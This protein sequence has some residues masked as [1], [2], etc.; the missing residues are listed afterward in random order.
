MFIRMAWEAGLRGEA[1]AVPT[2]GLAFGEAGSQIDATEA[3]LLRFLSARPEHKWTAAVCYNDVVGIGVCSAM[4]RAG[5]RVPQD[6]SVVGF[7][8][9]EA[10]L[11]IPRLTTVS[12]RL[13]HMGQR[14]AEMVMQMIND[15]T[16]V[17]RLRGTVEVVAPELVIRASTGPAAILRASS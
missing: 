4:A 5:I 7:D 10:Q 14:A 9:V 15:E 2:T 3:E 17:S 12:H 16:A 6:V 11:C 13:S 8:D 1:L